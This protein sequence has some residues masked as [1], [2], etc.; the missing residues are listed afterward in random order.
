MSH[1][2][3]SQTSSPSSSLKTG[4]VEDDRKSTF[5]Q[6]SGVPRAD[7]AFHALQLVAGNRVRH[8]RCAPEFLEEMS[9]RGANH[10]LRRFMAKKFKVMS[11]Q[12]AR[13]FFR[14]Y[15]RCAGSN[16]FRRLLNHKYSE[17]RKLVRSTNRMPSPIAFAVTAWD[18]SVKCVDYYM[19]WRGFKVCTTQ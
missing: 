12:E 14:S 17:H 10:S 11:G 8:G 6:E 4:D 16:S 18:G 5:S 3:S 1:S 9:T 15:I 13:L 7:G 19:T 2:G